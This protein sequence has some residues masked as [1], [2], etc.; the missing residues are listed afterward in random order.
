MKRKRLILCL[1]TITLVASLLYVYIGSG[2]AQDPSSL[3]QDQAN[4][5]FGAVV[6]DA[7]IPQL[8]QQHNVVP[9][10]VFMWTAGFRGRIGRTRPRALN[11]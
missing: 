2:T 9:Q 5:G 10:A 7:E 3:G 4:I 11:P 6:H 8:L 1:L